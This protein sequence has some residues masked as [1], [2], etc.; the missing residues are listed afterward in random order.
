MAGCSAIID[1]RWDVSRSIKVRQHGTYGLL[2][3]GLLAGGGPLGG[4]PGGGGRF[5]AAA[6]A[7]PVRGREVLSGSFCASFAL[8]GLV[9]L[10]GAAC[11]CDVFDKASFS[12]CFAAQPFSCRAKS[13]RITV[14]LQYWQVLGYQSHLHQ[15]NGHSSGTVA[16]CEGKV[17]GGQRTFDHGP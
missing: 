7:E 6:E 8:P 16:T 15:R 4:R 3:G 5:I 1:T 10:E 11:G 14:D 9:P 12:C 13:R 17:E 2:A